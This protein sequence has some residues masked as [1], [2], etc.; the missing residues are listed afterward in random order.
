VLIARRR[1]AQLFG[2]LPSR[3]HGA[4]SGFGFHVRI[5]RKGVWHHFT[6]RLWTRSKPLPGARGAWTNE[7]LGWR[8]FPGVR[9]HRVGYKWFI[10]LKIGLGGDRPVE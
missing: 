1:N 8:T 4:N 2:F 5:R 10:R 3:P 6:L 7:I 9:D